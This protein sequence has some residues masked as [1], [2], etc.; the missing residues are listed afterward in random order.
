MNPV[1]I[2]DIHGLII[3]ALS[4]TYFPMVS[5]KPPVTINFENKYFKDLYYECN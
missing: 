3:A 2:F 5:F 1:P 4:A